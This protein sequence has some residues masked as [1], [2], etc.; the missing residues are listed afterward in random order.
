MSNADTSGIHRLLDDAFAGIPVTPELQDLKEE[1]RGNLA[2]R[3]FELQEKGMDAG[4]A[5]QRAV[6]E[7]GDIDALI[8]SFGGPEAVD[9][10]RLASSDSIAELVK[11]NRVKPKPRFVVRTV[12]LSFILATGVVLQLL[13]ALGVLPWATPVLLLLAVLQIALPVGVIVT[14]ALRQETSQHY[15][16]PASRAIGFGLAGAGMALGLAVAGVYLSELSQLPLLIAAIVLVVLAVVAF[17]W[18]GVTQTNRTKPWALAMQRR[19]EA[20]DPFAADPAAAARFGMYTVVIWVLALA[21]FAVLSVTVGFAWSWLAIV[22]GLVGFMLTLARM[23]FPV[24][25]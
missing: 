8:A 12:I 15:A 9:G 4:A 7:L 17:T 24:K 20:E 25:R 21:G 18:L 5:A 10:T 1:L 16:S 2:A 23:V 3:A 13:G 14:D 6:T 22:A 19:Y 11:R